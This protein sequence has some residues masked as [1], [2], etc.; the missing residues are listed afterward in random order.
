MTSVPHGRAVRPGEWRADPGWRA[1]VVRLS[2]DRR[3]YR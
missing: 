3:L 2:S 1:P